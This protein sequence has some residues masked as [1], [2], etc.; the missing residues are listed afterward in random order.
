[1]FH[2]L[3]M[4][5]VALFAATFHS[6]A[7]GNRHHVVQPIIINHLVLSCHN[8]FNANKEITGAC[9]D[10]V[11]D[12]SYKRHHKRK[13]PSADKP[14]VIVILDVPDCSAA[15]GPFP[16]LQRS[17]SQHEWQTF[18]PSPSAMHLFVQSSSVR[19]S[20]RNCVTELSFWM[21]FVIIQR[22]SLQLTIELLPSDEEEI[23]QYLSASGP[24]SGVHW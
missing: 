17:S 9:K 1:M 24:C 10:C 23:S 21:V 16:L 19:Q 8:K 5:N 18:T 7:S 20:R 6:L 13:P 3:T 22:L 11:H 15:L 2:K 4:E 12:P 14:L